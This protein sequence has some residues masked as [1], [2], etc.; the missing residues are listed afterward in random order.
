MKQWM[1]F[2]W[3]LSVTL[4]STNMM[5]QPQQGCGSSGPEHYFNARRTTLPEQLTFLVSEKI[6]VVLECAEI[7]DIHT[8]LIDSVIFLMEYRMLP[9]RDS[10][11]RLTPPLLISVEP[12]GSGMLRIT[13]TSKPGPLAE[14]VANASTDPYATTH[15]NYTIEYTIDKHHTLV[16]YLQSLSALQELTRLEIGQLLQAAK[17]DIAKKKIARFIAKRITYPL[18]PQTLRSGR[19]LDTAGVF[20]HQYADRGISIS[21]N[22]GIGLL[23][24]TFVPSVSFP[25]TYRQSKKS[26]GF[27]HFGI[28]FDMLL[29]MDPEKP[30][31]MQKNWYADLLYGFSDSGI[32]LFAGYLIHRQGELIPPNACRLGFTAP[33]RKSGG[34]SYRVAYH[35]SATQSKQNLFE[36][37]IRYNF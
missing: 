27:Q 2:I 24:N 14:V 3:T 5:A 21:V 15:F 32:H 25:V 36:T 29:N 26:G 30:Y 35:F 11:A 10:L 22:T 20:I 37:G 16:L 34:L 31:R 17:D 12:I 23:N 33:I 13:T 6:I 4:T 9:I 28:G 19:S 8:H 18:S 1:L 7:Q